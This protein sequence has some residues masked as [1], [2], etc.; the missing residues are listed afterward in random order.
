MEDLML[1]AS[2]LDQ[3]LIYSHKTFISKEIDE[4]IRPVE[5]LDDRFISYM[6]QNALNALKEIA[7]KALFVPVTT[8]TKLQ[9]QRINFLSYGI[10]HQYAVTSNGGTIFSEGVEDSDWSRLVIEGRDKCLAAQDLIK[11]FE[12][13]SHSSWVL[14]DSGKMADE[15]FYYCLIDREKIPVTELAAFKLWARENN[16]EL[17]IQGRKLYLV[18]LNVNKKAAILYIKEKEGISCVVAAGDSLLDLDM[19]K[20]ADLGLAPAH[21]EL[22]SLHIQGKS[23]LEKIKFTQKSGI[24]AAEEILESI[25]W[26]LANQIVV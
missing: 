26:S 1:F 8:R 10:T 13:I 24:E 23:G 5:R 3:T 12:E 20:A 21:G 18:P 15:L 4:Q 25:P 16:W 22:Y 17:S 6:T 2:D 11:K 7:Q 9:Y 14:K 19:L